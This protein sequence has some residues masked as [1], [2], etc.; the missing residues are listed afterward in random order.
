MI[1]SLISA[2]ASIIGGLFGKKSN[3]D[4]REQQ[5][6]QFQENIKLQKEFAQNGIQW[7]AADAKAAGIHPLYALGAGTPSFSPVSSNFTADTSMP[8]ALAAAGQD[9][10]RAVN[11]TRS[12]SQRNNAF[13]DAVQKLSL[14]KMGLENEVLRADL[15]SKVSRVQQQ[16]GPPM[17]VGDRYLIPGQS[18]SGVV[19]DQP[20]KRVNVDPNAPFSEP[21][22]VADVGV[23]RTDSGLMIV[24]SSD[25]K[26]RIEDSPYEWTHFWRNMILPALSQ[27]AQDRQT[28]GF[29]PP[30]PGYVWKYIPFRG[31]YQQVPANESWYSRARRMWN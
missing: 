8:N 11:A 26:E 10:G 28:K 7:K 29:P 15:L 22:A 12:A 6:R 18:G 4:A 31:E 19:T 21:G 17:P 16:S 25:V 13:N 14:E 23:A 24:P 27:D 5:E 3:D 9:I 20:Q 1:G 2:G 30:K